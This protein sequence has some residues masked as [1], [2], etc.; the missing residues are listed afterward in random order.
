MPAIWGILN[1][2][3]GCISLCVTSLFTLD[4]HFVNFISWFLLALSKVCSPTLNK[5]I[6][7][8]AIVINSNNRFGN[9]FKA[10]PVIVFR[11]NTSLRQ[12]IG[13]NTVRVNEKKSEG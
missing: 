5:A 12:I 13:K 6:L 4:E 3:S 10:T 1:I 8:K 11:K 7:I 9:A 2:D